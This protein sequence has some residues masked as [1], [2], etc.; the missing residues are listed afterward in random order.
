MDGW[1]TIGTQLSTKQ[2]DKD[3][4]NEETK[5]K[6]YAK[7][8]EMLISAKVKIE[9]S[10]AMKEY[11]QLKKAIETSFDTKIELAQ[12]DKYIGYEKTIENYNQKK[13]AEIQKLNEAYSEQLSK[14]EEINQ[15]LISNTHQQELTKNKIKE[16]NQEYGKVQNLEQVKGYLDDA[17]NKTESIVKKVAKWGLAVFSVRSAYMFIRQSI[18]T[19]SQY[20][21][22]IATDIEYIRYALAS[23]LQPIIERI[24]QLAYKLLAYINYIS[25]AWFGVNIFANASA[26]SFDKARKS[27]GSAN[28][29][30]KELQKTLLGFDEMNI[31]QDGSTT[32]GG[33][34]GGIALPSFDLE[35]MEDVEIPSW[36]KWIAENGTTVALIIGAIATAIIGM[37][38]G[39]GTTLSGLTLLIGEI[40]NLI[41]NWD[42]MTKSERIAAVELAALGGA[43]TG[44]GLVMAGVVSGPIGALIGALSLLAGGIASVIIKNQEDETTTLSVVEADKKLKE[45]KDNLTSATSEYTNAVKNAENTSKQLLDIEKRTKLN[46]E[47]LYN[48]V[49]SGTLSYQDMNKAQRQVFDAYVKNQEAQERLTTVTEKYNKSIRDEKAARTEKIAAVYKEEEAYSG[50]L[51]TL[52][53]G[54]RAGKVSAEDMVNGITTVMNHMDKETKK[55]FVENLPDD[56]KKGFGKAGNYV[57]VFDDGFELSFKNVANSVDKAINK[58]KSL[59]K[60]LGNLAKS[61]AVSIS[62]TVKSTAGSKNAKGAIYYPPKLAT[63]GIINMPGRGVPL[64]A[65]GGEKGPEGVIPLTDQEA[66][67]RLGAEIG[68]NVVINTILNNYMNSRLMNREMLKTNNVDSFAFNG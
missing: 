46:G 35:K 8:N 40:V 15:K 32:K 64:G 27:M 34:G 9:K 58:V 62:T 51:K 39:I 3:L 49:I 13:N 14:I 53:D 30:A 50:Y 43:L 56:I 11:N 7:E 63:G 16:I 2:L 12:Q 33:G 31:L 44:L 25:Q 21:E 26:K 61:G 29:S 1:I 42:N 66:M 18:S 10:K 41:I 5:L 60:E 19:L 22:K 37:K 28:K 20:N 23:A 65:I 6:K 45:A 38:L 55:T 67:S 52:I 24:I 48:S 59:T 17:K 54:Y 68:R 47:Q 57:Q 4:K 36:V